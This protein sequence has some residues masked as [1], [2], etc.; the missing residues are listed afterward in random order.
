MSDHTEIVW[1]KGDSVMQEDVEH[2]VKAARNELLLRSLQLPIDAIDTIRYNASKSNKTI[3]EY[4]SSLIL[5]SIEV[6]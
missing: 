2:V 5:E 6:V 1:R 4:I 3:D